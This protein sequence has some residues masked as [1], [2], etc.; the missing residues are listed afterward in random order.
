M[1]RG[2]ARW[3]LVLVLLLAVAWLA[4]PDTALA[5][6][7]VIVVDRYRLT[8]DRV[9]IAEGQSV[10][11]QAAED[12]TLVG[13]VEPLTIVGDETRFRS[14]PLEPGDVWRLQL[15]ETGL[16]PYHVEEHPSVEGVIVVE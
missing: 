12:E 3:T 1:E 8:P 2:G 7:E 11:F 15:E 10:T 14:P 6:G 16:H 13:Y 9:T 5:G 4:G